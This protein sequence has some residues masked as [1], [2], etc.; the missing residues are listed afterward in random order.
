M[1]RM[2]TFQTFIWINWLLNSC[3]SF[4]VLKQGSLWN[5]RITYVVTTE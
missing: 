2:S 1:A 4:I 5:S 3:C